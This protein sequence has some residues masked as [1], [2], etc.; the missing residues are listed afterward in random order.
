MAA[1][2]GALYYKTFHGYKVA[3][4][5]DKCYKEKEEIHSLLASSFT[6]VLTISFKL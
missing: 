6:I 2:Q 5:W 3:Q 1:E 4:A